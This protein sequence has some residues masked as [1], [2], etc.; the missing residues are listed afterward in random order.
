MVTDAEIS[1]EYVHIARPL[2]QHLAIHSRTV[3]EAH[4]S[5]LTETDCHN[6]R[7]SMKSTS[8]VCR[9]IIARTMRVRNGPPT[10]EGNG[11]ASSKKMDDKKMEIPSHPERHHS[12]YYD[13]RHMPDRFPNA[14]LIDLPDVDLSASIKTAVYDMLTDTFTKGFPK[15]RFVDCLLYTSPSPRDQR[16]SRMPSS[17]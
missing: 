9:V 3:M 5:S 15:A 10:I 12:Y 17:A 6:V 14:S 1:D 16:G 13:N 2:L 4:Q 11:M 7:R 8:K